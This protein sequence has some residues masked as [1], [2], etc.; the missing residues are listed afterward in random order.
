VEHGLQRNHLLGNRGR[1]AIVTGE[2]QSPSSESSH[3]NWGL[4]LR[5][6]GGIGGFAAL[7]Y[8][9][10]YVPYWIRLASLGFPADVALRVAS[11][12]QILRQGFPAATTWLEISLAGA[13]LLWISRWPRLPVPHHLLQALS[14]VRSLSR[15]IRDPAASS[16]AIPTDAVED[17]WQ[18]VSLGW[19][20]LPLVGIL[21]VI[22]ARAPG[23]WRIFGFLV[24]MF[25]ASA[26]G[27][28]YLR[29]RPDAKAPGLML[30]SIIAA[31]VGVCLYQVGEP[32]IVE[33]VLVTPPINDAAVGP[34]PY[35][36]DDDGFVYIAEPT[37]DGRNGRVVYSR[38]I[39]ACR[40]DSL[41]LTFVPNSDP[42]T[43]LK[44]RSPWD[45]L[46]SFEPPNDIRSGTITKTEGNFAACDTPAGVKWSS[47]RDA[48]VIAIG[49]SG[50]YHYIN[51][52]LVCDILTI[53]PN[54]TGVRLSDGAGDSSYLSGIGSVYL[55]PGNWTG[56]AVF[57]DDAAA[58]SG[59]DQSCG[60][61]SWSLSLVPPN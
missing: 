34:L 46:W 57:N 13:C 12:A 44:P 51:V 16:D 47:D 5:A 55:T 58:P 48:G 39:V 18:Q 50:I 21:I 52:K 8:I 53:N 9:I 56:T 26:C 7:I 30:I 17:R 60:V 15:K 36:G 40:R 31:S 19:A 20:T 22:V 6:A 14:R 4:I 24:G 35:F 11:Q 49:V 28:L 27:L 29:M 33:N 1:H 41:S 2:A 38:G 37:S 54:D 42:I 32:L 23:M 45:V 10:G 61:Q 25:L 43:L 3:D 59:S